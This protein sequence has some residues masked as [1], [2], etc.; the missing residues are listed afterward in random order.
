VNASTT[1]T[2]NVVSENISDLTLLIKQSQA[3]YLAAKAQKEDSFRIYELLYD[4][5]LK[6]FQNLDAAFVTLKYYARPQIRTMLGSQVPQKKAMPANPHFGWFNT[7]D[8][9]VDLP[10]M[11][12]DHSLVNFL[13]LCARANI[14][15]GVKNYAL[16]ERSGNAEKIGLYFAH[17]ISRLDGQWDPYTDD[18]AW[19]V[20]Y[21]EQLDEDRRERYDQIMDAKLH[22]DF[23]QFELMTPKALLLLHTL[24]HSP[25]CTWN[26]DSRD[27]EVKLYNSRE[28]CDVL[29]VTIYNIIMFHTLQL[30]LPAVRHHDGQDFHFQYTMF[31]TNVLELEL[32]NVISFFFL[33][34]Y[35]LENVHLY[36][37]QNNLQERS[38]ECFGFVKVM[39]LEAI[40]GLTAMLAGFAD[41]TMPVR[42]LLS[43][44]DDFSLPSV[45]KHADVSSYII[46]L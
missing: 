15:H 30:T 23:Y 33:T 17:L 37:L 41:A 11:N 14:D 38:S 3:Y 22:G 6:P 27:K 44:L 9:L 19:Y 35:R 36:Q 26:V 25:E 2:Y 42:R 1:E 10:S 40:A 18:H 32:R 12:A 16:H 29:I 13:Y 45:Y 43:L 8:E 39:V 7:R 31:N 4:S 5:K 20:G 34:A 28:L 46:E 21:T 24:G